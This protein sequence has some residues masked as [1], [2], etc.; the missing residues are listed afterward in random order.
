METD[1][2]DTEMECSHESKESNEDEGKIVEI[3]K[4]WYNRASGKPV[5]YL[6]I[7]FS[8]IPQLSWH[9]MTL[10]ELDAPKLVKK[11]CKEKSF[12]RKDL[13]T[14]KKEKDDGQEGT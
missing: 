2:N 1:P 12:S 13:P 11:Y 7:R 8:N 10:T 14:K 9:S 6:Q 5:L 3:K 4:H